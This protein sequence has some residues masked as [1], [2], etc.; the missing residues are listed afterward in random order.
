MK[1]GRIV[2]VLGLTLFLFAA[3]GS[4]PSSKTPDLTGVSSYYV[5]ANGNDKNTGTSEDSPFKTLTKALEVAAKTQVK[6]IT[7][8]GTLVG[9]TSTKH[10]APVSLLGVSD[11]NTLYSKEI[12]ITGKPDATGEEKAVLTSDTEHRALEN[13]NAVIRLEN[14][15]ISGCKE[16][17]VF[18][19]F[20]LLTLA[21][22]AK[23]INNNSENNSMIFAVSSI[24]FLRDD[25]EISNN[26]SG[27][28]TGITL[29]MNSQ[30]ILMDNALVANNISSN[31]GGG[32]AVE[33]STLT[34]K[35]NAMVT[36]NSAVNAGG[37]IIAYDATKNGSVSKVTISGNAGVIQNSAKAGGGIFMHKNTLILQDTARVMENT[38][39]ELGGG[40]VIF[41]GASGTRGK[42]IIVT[43]NKAPQAADIAV[44]N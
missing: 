3:C 12:L 41:S 29:S 28:N 43:G 9:A 36:K 11:I 24:V 17:A 6:K 21:K 22:G 20:G 44:A 30:G 18:V 14:I 39:S 40:I 25:A 26:K 31:N 35:D 8:I 42:D 27:N 10:L 19:G 16:G 23:I 1:K 32:I 4:S 38:A 7:V 5:R 33:D 2:L 34:M 13:L 37:G 15:E